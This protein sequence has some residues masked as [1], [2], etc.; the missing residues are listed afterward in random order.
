M[1]ITA[2]VL[3][4][5]GL[6]LSAVPIINNFALILVVLAIIFGIVGLVGI[7]KGKASGFGIAIASLVISIIAAIVVLASQA[8][9]S[10]ALNEASSQLD[11]VTGAATEEVLGT[12]VEVTPGSLKLKKSSYG[13]VDSELPITVKNLT[14]EQASFSI[15]IEAVNSNGDRIMQ[16]YIFAT[17]LGPGQ[18][19]TFKAF[20]AVT[21]D[22]YE[23]MKTAKFQII[24][25]GAY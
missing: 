24:S 20:Q 18:S 15:Q 16:D 21:S 4:I 10:V 11:R 23:A 25:V 6:V 1:A 5:I 14:D 9:Y 12:D 13:L 19:Q 2:L 3:G 17:D 8:L 22:D 7:T